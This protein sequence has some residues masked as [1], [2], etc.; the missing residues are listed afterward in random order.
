ML[1]DPF[2]Q[3]HHANFGADNALSLAGVGLDD[4]LGVDRHFARLSTADLFLGGIKGLLEDGFGERLVAMNRGSAFGEIGT[5]KLD[6]IVL[7]RFEVTLIGYNLGYI[8]A[9]SIAQQ[10]IAIYLIFPLCVLA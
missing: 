6:H 7:P 4:E 1:A 3:D 2:A 8:S 10:E 9:T 5:C